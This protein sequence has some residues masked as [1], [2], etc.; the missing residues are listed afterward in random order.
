M[1]A[2]PNFYDY[3]SLNNEMIHFSQKQNASMSIFI[4]ISVQEYK[5]HISHFNWT[6]FIVFNIKEFKLNILTA[7][8]P[9]A[10]ERRQKLEMLEIWSQRENEK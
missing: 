7:I 4:N 10:T 1:H 2:L 6:S 5:P 8:F 9:G 3:C